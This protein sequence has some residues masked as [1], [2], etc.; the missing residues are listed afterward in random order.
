MSEYAELRQ[1]IQS[2]LRGRMISALR[3]R[4]RIRRS[5]VR[6]GNGSAGTSRTPSP[7]KHHPKPCVGR[8][9]CAR[10]LADRGF[11]ED[12]CASG[13]VLPGRR[14]RRHLRNGDSG[15]ILLPINFTCFQ[16]L[17]PHAEIGKCQNIHFFSQTSFKERKKN[18]VWLTTRDSSLFCRLR[19]CLRRRA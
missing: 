9:A 13:M 19:T 3:E 6:I 2:V 7:T 1:S 16:T 4:E 10:R 12:R 18:P 17:F 15:N 14:G 5:A 8:V 11:A